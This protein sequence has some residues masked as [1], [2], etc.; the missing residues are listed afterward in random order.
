MLYWF[1]NDMGENILSD[2]FGNLEDAVAYAQYWANK[3]HVCININ[4]GDDIIDWV[5]P[6]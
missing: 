2:Y 5:Y 1:T 6:H 3:L 4:E